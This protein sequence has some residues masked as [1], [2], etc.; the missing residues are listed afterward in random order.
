MSFLL[1]TANVHP[2]VPKARVDP[3]KALIAADAGGSATRLVA[4][5]L[6]LLPRRRWP[7]ARRSVPRILIYYIYLLTIIVINYVTYVLYSKGYKAKVC[8]TCFLRD[9]ADGKAA[10]AGAAQ[11][12]PNKVLIGAVTGGC[13][14][15]LA[16]ALALLLMWRRRRAVRSSESTQSKA[17][18]GS[19]VEKCMTAEGAAR[20]LSLPQPPSG[21][22]RLQVGH[23]LSAALAL[24]SL[25]KALGC[26]YNRVH[27]VLKFPDRRC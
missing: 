2:L 12:G 11:A 13:A 9:A 18:K 26:A 23:G 6:L 5:L 16:A 15:L 14:A 19:E 22:M 7:A 4:A 3:N 24:S 1:A 21:N 20:H 17:S 27:G 8:M 10:P 25:V